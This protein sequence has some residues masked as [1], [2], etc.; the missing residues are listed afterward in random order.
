MWKEE[1]RNEKK[2]KKSKRKSLRCDFFPVTNDKY[3]ER[4]K[5]KIKNSLNECVHFIILDF[6]FLPFSIPFDCIL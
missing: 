4:K 3:E 6:Y 5:I 2:K 1:I